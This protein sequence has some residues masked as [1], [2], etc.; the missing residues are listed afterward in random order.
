MIELILLYTWWPTVAAGAFGLT[1]IIY[2][3]LL[4][5]Y[6]TPGIPKR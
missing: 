4:Q 3:T 2:H 6:T 5:L 1:T